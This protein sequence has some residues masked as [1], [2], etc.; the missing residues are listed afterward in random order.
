MCVY[1]LGWCPR[2]HD[3]DINIEKC[4]DAPP[5]NPNHRTCEHSRPRNRELCT[6]LSEDCINCQ[7]AQAHVES[8][9]YLRPPIIFLPTGRFMVLPIRLTL[10]CYSSLDDFLAKNKFFSLMHYL[11]CLGLE[12]LSFEG[13]Q[14]PELGTAGGYYRCKNLPEATSSTNPTALRYPA[15]IA[16]DFPYSRPA[17]YEL[18]CNSAP[19]RRAVPSSLPSSRPNL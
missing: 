11:D 4:S 14:G 9:W 2:G 17:T 15:A 13:T 10:Q 5:E 18:A 12:L 7:R 3:K 8:E 1:D 16:P 19:T 6:V